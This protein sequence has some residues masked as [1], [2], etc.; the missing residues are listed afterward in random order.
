MQ[1]VGWR[2]LKVFCSIFFPQKLSHGILHFFS[3]RIIPFWYCSKCVLE[4]H[5]FQKQKGKTSLACREK[6]SFSFYPNIHYQFVTFRDKF[7]TYLC[8]LIE[9]FFRLFLGLARRGGMCGQSGSC[10]MIL[11]R[12]FSSAVTIA[13]EIAHSW[14]SLLIVWSFTLIKIT[15]VKSKWEKRGIFSYYLHGS[16]WY[17]QDLW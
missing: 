1:Q 13:H 2:V 16:L 10:S 6:I 15:R 14:V 4:C 12:G 9:Y 7:I 11:D 17:D 3:S 5:S 8:R